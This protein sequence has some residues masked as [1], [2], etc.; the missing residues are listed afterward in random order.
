[1]DTT[2]KILILAPENFPDNSAGAIYYTNIGK[3]FQKNGYQVH[4]LGIGKNFNCNPIILDSLHYY[5]LRTGSTDFFSNILF[6]IALPKLF[7]NFFRVFLD[8][9]KPNA[10]LFS[11]HGF[12][13]SFLK[14]AIKICKQRNITVYLSCVEIFRQHPL[15]NNYS[16][17]CNNYFAEKFIDSDVRVIAI[18]TF[19]YN[20]FIHRRMNAFKLPPVFENGTFIQNSEERPV[21]RFI[22]CGSPGKKDCLLR[23]LEVFANL[24][25]DY[26][27]IFTIVGVDLNWF[28]SHLKK[29]I[30]HTM[31]K[32]INVLGRLD[33]NQISSLYHNSDF[34]LLLRN[35]ETKT[36]KA[37]FPTKVSESLHYG[38]PVITNYSSDLSIYLKD[39]QNAIISK[40]SSFED[41]RQATIRALTVSD[42]SLNIMK[43]NAF[44]T[45]LKEL[46]LD[47]FCNSFK[48]FIK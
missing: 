14:K 39:N 20:S 43:N 24:S 18:S 28:N 38:I 10:V 3:L 29:K 40:S 4:I 6:H 1:M 42:S 23:I 9:Q 47:A 13:K 16:T 35:P 5:S 33:H 44:N 7:K 26:N 12:K 11:T 34:S 2:K 27:F 31:G 17:I 41:F 8:N 45:S 48:D 15:F 32:K 22:Y 36:S 25:H 46:S 19:L 37:G 21:R 30:L